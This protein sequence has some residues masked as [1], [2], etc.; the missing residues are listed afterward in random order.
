[1]LGS[2]LFTIFIN[3]K[4]RAV[5]SKVRLF[6]DN[7]IVYR[8]VI[9]NEV[10]ESLQTDTNSLISWAEKWSM[11]FHPEKCEVIRVTN[12]KKPLNFAY[13]TSDHLV[14]TVEDKKYLGLTLQK[15]LSGT[16]LECNNESKQH[17]KPNT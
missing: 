11:L 9:T 8:P 4:P 2:I 5:D 12:K 17:L 3:E 14:K 6:A 15:S 16:E 13:K 7:C 10:A 1:M